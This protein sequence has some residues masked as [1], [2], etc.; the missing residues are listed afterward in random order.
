MFLRSS[1][2][3]PRMK[4]LYDA[5]G[6]TCWITV[7]ESETTRYLELDG[8]EEGAMD[9]S[10]AAPVFQYLWFHKCSCLT[11]KRAANLLVIGAGAFT[12]AKCLALDHPQAQVETV[13]VEGDLRMVGRR[14]FGLDRP[15]FGRIAFHG[16]PAEE[17]MTEIQTRYDFVFDDLFD[18]FQHVPHNSRAPE[19]FT[20]LRNVVVD[21]GIII[22]NLIW[23]PHS[24]DT[25]HACEE[26]GAA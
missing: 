17:F 7:C 13:D 2:N 23:N 5:P 9:L 22:K 16:V 3:L 14:F 4:M 26:A 11:G 1:N 12:A 10:S 15:E 8:C 6:K 20:Q 18:G 19:H 21:G 25:R 24:A